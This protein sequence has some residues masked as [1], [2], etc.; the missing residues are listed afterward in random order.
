MLATYIFPIEQHNFT[1][2][3][4]APQ[5]YDITICIVIVIEA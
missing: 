2:A 1:D 3:T 4:L 5:S